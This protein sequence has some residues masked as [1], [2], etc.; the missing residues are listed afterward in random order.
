MQGCMSKWIRIIEFRLVYKIEAPTLAPTIK[1]TLPIM[2]KKGRHVIEILKN[3][4][5]IREL[6]IQEIWPGK[7]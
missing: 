5:K 3:K 1:A 6:K 7:I 4:F 2:S